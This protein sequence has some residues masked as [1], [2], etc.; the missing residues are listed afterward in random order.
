MA[1]A[2]ARPVY[3][4]DADKAALAAIIEDVLNIE[5]DPAVV[6]A[7]AAKMRLEIARH[8]KPRGMFDIKLAPGGLVDLEFAVHTLQLSHRTAFAPRLGTAVAALIEDGLVPP[9]IADAHRL[10][11]RMLVTLR[12]VAPDSTEPAAASRALVARA[13]RQ[14]G[15]EELLAAHEAA[16]Q[17]I[18]LLWRK[19]TESS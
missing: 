15:W 14:E 3:G 7:D 18:S 1:L 6:A 19:V 17:S 13:C 5:R 9:A 2:R 11:V 10:L 4:S 8:K 16:R 12:L